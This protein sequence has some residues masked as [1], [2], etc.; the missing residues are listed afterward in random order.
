M[1]KEVVAP[2]AKKAAE[3]KAKEVVQK[4]KKVAAKESKNEKEIAPAKE[5]EV[6]A[7]PLK[8]V[9]T[10]LVTLPKPETEKSPYFDIARK[11]NILIEFFPFVKVEGISGRDFKK[12]KLDIA[13][14]T[15]IIFTS[16]NAV[17]HF[18]RICEEMKVKIS[19]EMKYFCIS[20]AIA[21]YLQ[22]YILYRKRKVFYSA[23]GTTEGL[24][25][26]IAKHKHQEQYILPTADNGKSDINVFLTRNKI[27]FSEATLYRTVSNDI[28]V[29]M[30]KKYDLLLFF[31]S[32]SIQTLFDYFPKF[33]QGD[34]IIGSFGPATA[35]AILDAG[36]RLDMNAPMPGA[37]SMSAALDKFLEENK[38]KRKK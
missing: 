22:K 2:K 5:K 14:H 12:Q 19:Q 30:K 25:E 1:S 34:T 20:E 15:A 13:E 18:F 38:K 27:P 35:K 9:H 10:V 8:E 28:T 6:K 11:Y 4:V 3:P 24:L 32:L 31:S 33:K 17:E 36:L 16:R 21:L 26:V 23:D 37:P 7:E 29:L